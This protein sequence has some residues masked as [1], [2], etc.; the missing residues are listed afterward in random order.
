VDR[1]VLGDLE[2]HIDRLL[3]AAFFLANDVGQCL[4]TTSGVREAVP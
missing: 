1:C 2:G 3:G 4:I